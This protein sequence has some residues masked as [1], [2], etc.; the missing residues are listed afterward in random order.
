VRKREQ[1]GWCVVDATDQVLRAIRHASW[2]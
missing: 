2:R 1:R